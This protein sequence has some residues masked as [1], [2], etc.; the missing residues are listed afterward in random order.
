MERDPHLESK[1]RLYVNAETSLG[2]GPRDGSAPRHRPNQWCPSS[3]TGSAPCAGVS[4]LTPHLGF[5]CRGQ[6]MAAKI[7]AI[8]ANRER[9]SKSRPCIKMLPARL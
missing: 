5:V 2:V 6:R 3:S 8:S 7:D 1:S 9:A 4:G